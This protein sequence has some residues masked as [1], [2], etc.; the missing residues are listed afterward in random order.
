MD[1]D[2]RAFEEVGQ[3]TCR[4]PTQ[5]SKPAPLFLVAGRSAGLGDIAGQALERGRLETHMRAVSVRVCAG[6]LKI[7]IG[8]M[9][10]KHDRYTDK[11]MRHGYDKRHTTIGF[12][13]MSA[14]TRSS[15]SLVDYGRSLN[16]L[17]EGRVF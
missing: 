1:G 7:E 12:T 17:L 10:K 13:N 5:A 8:N 14:C 11:L 15:D 16:L 4:G 3:A 9:Q 6:V 2:K